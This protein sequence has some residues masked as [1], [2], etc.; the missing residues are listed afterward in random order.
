[1]SVF[2]LAFVGVATAFLAVLLKRYQP[3]YALA[4]I[5]FGGAVILFF[6]VSDIGEIL[7]TLSELISAGGVS[8]ENTALI[9]KA[10]GVGYVT[11]F[12]SEI[13]SDC[14]EKGISSK[15]ELAGRLTV[16]GLCLPVVSAFLETVG[17]FLG[18]GS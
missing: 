17:N 2:A 9:F 8:P 3:E 4:A 15:V 11:Q 1:M 13:C 18:G 7:D 16:V 10:L 12:A 14:G 6:L 5:L